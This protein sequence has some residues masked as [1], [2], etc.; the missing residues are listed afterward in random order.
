[1]SCRSNSEPTKFR[2]SLV[3]AS[4]LAILLSSTIAA[5][6]LAAAAEK[7]TDIKIKTLGLQKQVPAI[8]GAGRPVLIS[9]RGK[10]YKGLYISRISTRTRLYAIGVRPADIVLSVN[11]TAT[12]GAAELNEAV[13]KNQA[14]ELKVAT[15]RRSGKS[16]AFLDFGKG[17]R[18]KDRIPKPPP[19]PL[20][21]EPANSTKAENPDDANNLDSN[22]E[23][24]MLEAKMVSLVNSE[25]Q[26]KGLEQLQP[27]RSLASVAKAH[28]EDM[29]RR[30]YFSHIDPD[31]KNPGDRAAAAG[32]NASYL[33]ENIAS[34][35]YR[36]PPLSLMER[37][38]KSLMASQHHRENILR[39]G[40]KSIGIGISQDPQKGALKVTQIFS[41]DLIP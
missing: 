2:K 34:E 20:Q 37:A 22:D 8:L 1:M 18:P 38:H 9:I 17:E 36:E 10:C 27:S 26:K 11:G 30:G 28:S 4:S 31:G 25:R 3:L 39:P 7:A 14:K 19:P 41:A 5:P 35:N 23:L 29:I 40:L 16:I 32:I 15:A 6:V 24:T 12:A 33:A 13:L 21:A